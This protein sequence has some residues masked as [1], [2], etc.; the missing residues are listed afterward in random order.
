M[1]Y[2]VEARNVRGGLLT[3]EL[4]DVTDGIALQDVNGLHPVG[5][6]FAT[7]SSVGRA[8]TQ[9]H[10]ARR[11]DRQIVIKL[12]LVPDFVTTTPED[13]RFDKIYK[14]FMP[15]SEVKLTLFLS[16]GLELECSGRVKNCEAPPFSKDPEVD[17]TIICF[18]PDFV[19]MTLV[20]FEGET[21]SSTDV[22]TITY[23]GNIETGVDF[24]LNV[25][26]TITEFTI[27]HTPPDGTLRTT[28]IA[29]A[30]VNGDILELSTI[31][32]EKGL[33]LTRTGTK[34][35][36][37]YGMSAQSAWPALSQGDNDIRVY[38]E[39]A[40]IPYTISYYTRYGGL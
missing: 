20:E 33:W 17:I 2:K 24:V 12:G 4:E 23:D 25:D 9:F 3:L 6:V 5:A 30:M 37:L 22:E 32:G 14:F 34:T 1:L 35:S 40:A 18:D 26:R 13:L 10:S 19:D 21:T 7:S 31:P 15:Q 36:V 39:G 11:E 29:V 38:A 28:D 8:G 27:Y 16:G